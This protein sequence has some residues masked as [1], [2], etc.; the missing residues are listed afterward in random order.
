MDINAFEQAEAGC[1]I[2]Q[3]LS[4]AMNLHEEHS[5]LIGDER[6]S[7]EKIHTRLDNNWSQKMKEMAAMTD[8]GREK[9]FELFAQRHERDKRKWYRDEKLAGRPEPPILFRFVERVARW[10]LARCLPSG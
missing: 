2:A 6:S 10:R 3:H 9:L 8:Q 1:E 7:L 4:K 5:V